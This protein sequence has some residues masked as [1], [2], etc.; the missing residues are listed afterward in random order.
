MIKI[1]SSLYGL[2]VFATEQIDARKKILQ[3]DGKLIS[4]DES[5]LSG[6]EGTNALQVGTIQYMDIV[7]PGV[8]VNHSCE[9]NCGIKDNIFL[10]AL[11][12][13]EIG[14]ELFYDYSTTV[15]EDEWSMRCSCMS[16]ECRGIISDFKYL[17]KTIR[18]R[19]LEQSVVQNFISILYDENGDRITPKDSSQTPVY[20]LPN[21]EHSYKLPL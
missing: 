15:E 6:N 5:L 4:F 21:T 7:E 10:I 2:G 9:P 11:R 17:R 20:T 12:K 18:R 14:E 16:D 13:I 8:I 3:F 1:A 19:Y